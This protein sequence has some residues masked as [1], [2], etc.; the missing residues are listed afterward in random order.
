M[1][2][3]FI[4]LQIFTGYD[5]DVDHNEIVLLC[6]VYVEVFHVVWLNLPWFHF[7]VAQFRVLFVEKY[8]MLRQYVLEMRDHAEEHLVAAVQ[9][10]EIN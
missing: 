3:S 6:L 1:L 10:S 9:V 5:D 4:Q 2:I 7:R 8:L